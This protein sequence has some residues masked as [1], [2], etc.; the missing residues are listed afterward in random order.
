MF[1]VRFE[2]TL[3]AGER[4]QTYNLRRAATGTDKAVS[5]KGKAIPLQA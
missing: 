5:K 2:S 4:L 3:S 1:S